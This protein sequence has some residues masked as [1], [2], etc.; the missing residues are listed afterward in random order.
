VPVLTPFHHRQCSCF[1]PEEVRIF[2]PAFCFNPPRSSGRPLPDFWTRDVEPAL[3]AFGALA[4]YGYVYGE[5][6]R[7]KPPK[8]RPRPTD[9]LF[10]IDV[11]LG[12]RNVVFWGTRFALDDQTFVDATGKLVRPTKWL[13]LG[14]TRL[15]RA[16]FDAVR[17]CFEN[18][19][20][21]ELTFAEPL[22]SHLEPGF[23]DR[24]SIEFA[25]RTWASYS[26]L[27]GNPGW[28]PNKREIR[29]LGIAMRLESIAPGGPGL[30]ALWAMEGTIAV[31]WSYLVA[32]KHPEWLLEPGLRA[33]ELVGPPIEE[34]PTSL[35]FAREWEMH[36]ILD[37]RID[38]AHDH[39]SHGAPK[40][41]RPPERRRAKR[42]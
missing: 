34:R 36:T 3:N 15:E 1:R 2:N 6:I 11:E 10:A 31:A 14:H 22:R 9:P 42:A 30:I 24:F 5:A 28:K 39:G 8:R 33:V 18:L 16:V 7:N 13:P 17:P 29:T 40:A 25:Q 23:E 38:G 26:A 21:K 12:P 32:T 20:R 27:G 41:V 37:Y 4:P 35:R 19:D